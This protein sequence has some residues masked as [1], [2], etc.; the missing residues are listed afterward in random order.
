MTQEIHVQAQSDHIASLAGGAPLAAL[1]ELI[2][3]ALDADARTVTVDLVT[4]P[5]GGLDAIRVTDDGAGIDLARVSDTFGGLGGSWKRDSNCTPGLHRR[6][7]GRHGRGR[8][9]AFALGGHVEW[10]TTSGEPRRSFALSG[11]LSE[12]GLFR[13]EETAPGPA[14]GT[15]V[16]IANV[17]P[18]ADSLTNAEVTVQTLAAK[19][20]LYLKNYPDVRIYFAGIPVTPVIVQKAATDYRITLPSGQ[21]AK[22]EII[23]WRRR[24]PGAGRLV[25]CGGDGFSLRDVAAGLRG[26]AAYSFTAY[27]VS[28]RL[29]DLEA[30][31]MLVMDE[32]NP[33]VRAYLDAARKLLHDHFAVRA[34]AETASRTGAWIADGTY[35]FAPD[36]VSPQRAAFDAAAAE[37]R[38]NLE[39]F[40]ALSA[41]ERKYLFSLLLRLRSIPA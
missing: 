33:E 38:A 14:A 5:L 24:F 13:L 37:L 1:E 40:D 10:R 3:N 31:N 20:A 19:F 30:E 39:G 35:P 34:A 7:H 27:L 25:L 29:A 6:L 17:R 26:C 8:F 28:P 12:P 18:S 22:L 4:N 23:E 41:V 21:E 2:W 11:D 9:K 36:D 16:F 15:E 32:L